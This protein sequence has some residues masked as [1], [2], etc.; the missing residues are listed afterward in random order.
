MAIYNTLF[1]KTYE[2]I[3]NPIAKVNWTKAREKVTGRAFN[4][5]E[6]DLDILR[7]ALAS[8]YYIICTRRSSNMSTY[9]ISLAN[10]VKTGKPSH[11]SHVLMNLEGDDPLTDDDYQLY[12]STGDGVHLSPFSKV[13]D[14]D[15]VCLLR[16]KH[17]D[18]RH[19]EG[20]VDAAKATLGR[21]YDNWFDLKDDTRMSCVELARY[22]LQALPDYEKKFA[23]FEAEIARVG[24]LTPQ[25]FYDSEDFE[26][27]IE[28]RR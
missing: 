18:G 26:K 17:V 13:F 5:T 2:K 4:L 10:I 15:S 8:N 1:Y 12:E 14:C 24:N 20:V 25:M 9:L 22:C 3:L 11:Y 27:V 16:P 19:W 21:Q 23:K 28:F 6:C 7:Q